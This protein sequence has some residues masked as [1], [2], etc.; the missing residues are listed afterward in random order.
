MR[1]QGPN[2]ENEDLVAIWGILFLLVFSFFLLSHS[3][4]SV[5]LKSFL[6][7]WYSVFMHG[8]GFLRVLCVWET[9]GVPFLFPST[10]LTGILEV[11]V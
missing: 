2:S 5:S 6:S 9:W 10:A 8:F 1:F 11:G 4:I 3:H 7:C